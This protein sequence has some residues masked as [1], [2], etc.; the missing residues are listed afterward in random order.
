MLR[1]ESEYDD[2]PAWRKDGVA[3]VI[4]SDTG[5]DYMCLMI[6]RMHRLLGAVVDLPPIVTWPPLNPALSSSAGR[7]GGSAAR[8]DIFLHDSDFASAPKR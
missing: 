6:T 8:V 2:G 3:V 4:E 5:T 1:L 7:D